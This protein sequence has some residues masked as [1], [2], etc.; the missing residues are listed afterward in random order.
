MPSFNFRKGQIGTEVIVI[1][2]VIIVMIMIGLF[3]NS[4]ISDF[5]ADVQNTEGFHNV[6]KEEVDFV[7]DSYPSTVDNMIAI[8]FV[9][10]WIGT[11]ISAF[12]I[13][14]H[15]IFFVFSLIILIVI[16]VVCAILTN[17]YAEIVASSEISGD[18]NL[19]PISNF[20]MNNLLIV[21]VVVGF[22]ILAVLYGK[23]RFI[24]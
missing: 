4:I 5:N 13:D 11:L 14:S 3:F 2:V 12:F 16:L 24:G 6:T 20:I 15:P 7:S 17:S 8:A 21:G 19:F 23:N 18:E 1:V 22:S 9:L 10:L